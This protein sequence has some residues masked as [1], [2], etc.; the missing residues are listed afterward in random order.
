MHT[1]MDI[2]VIMTHKMRHCLNDRVGFLGAGGTVQIDKRLAMHHLA[3]G[4]KIIPPAASCGYDVSD[5]SHCSTRW[6]K[7]LRTV[8]GPIKSSAPQMKD[9][10]SSARAAAASIPRERK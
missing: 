9:C 1:A 6:L 2:G 3:Q 10:T 5:S 8:S 4:R 7:A